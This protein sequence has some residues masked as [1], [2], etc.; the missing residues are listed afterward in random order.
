[1]KTFFLK[2]PR[3]LAPTETVVYL[4]PLFI[5]YHAGIGL[6]PD[7]PAVIVSSHVAPVR[8][9][10]GSESLRSELNNIN[11]PGYGNVFTTINEHT[12]RFAPV[13]EQIRDARLP[14]DNT[15]SV[16]VCSHWQ[17]SLNNT[18]KKPILY[19]NY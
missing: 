16:V 12:G 19:T 6:S 3:I 1:M 17:D 15:V 7:S 9:D 2:L 18:A 4:V 13:L 8:V 10:S 5:I 14:A 11:D